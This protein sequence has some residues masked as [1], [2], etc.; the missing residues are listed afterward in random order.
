MGAF[1]PNRNMHI[2]ANLGMLATRGIVY[3]SRMTTR[4]EHRAQIAEARNVFGQVVARAR[5]AGEP[6][7]LLNRK[8]EAAVVVPFDWYLRA[9]DALGEQRLLADQPD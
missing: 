1:S 5:F 6:T 4:R 3:S 8:A 2:I 9:L 7:V